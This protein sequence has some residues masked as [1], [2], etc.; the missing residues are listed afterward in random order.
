[1]SDVFISY[2][3][4][5]RVFARRLFD[6][7]NTQ[8]KETWVDWEDIPYSTEWWQEICSGIEGADTFIIIVTPSALGSKICNDELTY[9]YQLNKRIVPIIRREIK[10]RELAGTWFEK[11]WEFQARENW[12]ILKKINWLFFRRKDNCE[13][14]YNDKNELLNP[15]CDGKDCDHDNFD[16]AFTALL[17]SLATDLEHVRTHTR[18]LV[19]A[20]EWDKKKR[21]A[22]FLLRGA[23]LRDAENWLAEA[24]GKEQ[25]PDELHTEYILASRTAERKR[26]Q[27]N[28][29]ALAVGLLVAISLAIFGLIQSMN[30]N[31]N[32]MLAVAAEGTAIR[33]RDE[34]VAR[35][36]ALAASGASEAGDTPLG[37]A[38]ALEAYRLNPEDPLVHEA[39]FDQTQYPE[40]LYSLE[41][42]NMIT[43]TFF[44]PDGSVMY[45][46]E[47][48]GLIRAW[49]TASG[50][51]VNT[52][53]WRNTNAITYAQQFSLSPDASRLL[54]GYT[55]GTA[56]IHDTQNG[57]ILQKLV[58][59]EG[60]IWDVQWSPDSS[61]VLTSTTGNET[62]LP[63]AIVW[64]VA[65]GER[66]SVFEGHSDSLVAARFMPDGSR[67]IS[68]GGEFDKPNSQIFEWDAATGQRL[69]QID[70]D[71]QVHT[72][73]VLSMDLSSDG[74]LLAVASRDDAKLVIWNMANNNAVPLCQFEGLT[75]DTRAIEVEFSPDDAYLL[76]G[77]LGGIVRL[78]NV[79]DCREEKT[80]TLSLP[81]PIYGLAFSPDGTS[82]LISAASDNP[83]DY[84]DRNS[85]IIQRWFWDTDTI[86]NYELPQYLKENIQGFGLG[87]GAAF[88]DDN[89]QV[90]IT[91]ASGVYAFDAVSGTL[92]ARRAGLLNGVTTAVF[93][94]DGDMLLEGAADGGLALWNTATGELLQTQAQLGEISDVA[95]NHDDTLALSASTDGSVII[96][97]VETFISI[98]RFDGHGGE[99]V[100]FAHFLPDGSAVLS[101][102]QHPSGA[103][104]SLILWDVSTGNEIQRQDFEDG[105]EVYFAGSFLGAGLHEVGLSPDGTRIAYISD[106]ADAIILLET[107]SFEEVM[108]YEISSTLDGL[109]FSPASDQI[110]LSSGNGQ[111]ELINILTGVQRRLIGHQSMIS[112][113]AFSPDGASLL[114]FSG[115]NV[116]DRSPLQ[117]LLWDLASEAN[118]VKTETGLAI[119]GLFSAQ[120][121]SPDGSRFYVY[122]FDEQGRIIEFDSITL[123]ETRR[124]LVLEEATTDWIDLVVSPDGRWLAGAQGTSIILWEL[125]T[126]ASYICE[127]RIMAPVGGSIPAYTFSPDSSRILSSSPSE[128]G[129]MI[130]WDPVSCDILQTYSDP[131]NDNSTIAGL[132]PEAVQKLREVWALVYSPDGQYIYSGGGRTTNSGLYTEATASNQ[133]IQWDASTGEIIQRFLVNNSGGTIDLAITADGTRLAQGQNL[134]GAT[135]WD[136]TTYQPI[137]QLGD[138]NGYVG[139]VA[140][141]PNGKQLL[142]GF[143]NGEII[144]WDIDTGIE[145]SKF[146]NFG[147]VFTVNFIP[148][149]SF[150]LFSTFDGEDSIG[151]YRWLTSPEAIAAWLRANRFIRDF[152]CIERDQYNI[153]PLCNAEGIV[154]TQAIIATSTP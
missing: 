56:L 70:P 125:T 71:A 48:P 34:A 142:T 106:A 91:V 72:S 54:I 36:L 146:T 79:V 7:L 127:T 112:T 126:G 131:D 37:N 26:Q 122:D 66:V 50:L 24:G 147:Q 57:A 89:Q 114:V 40:I 135:V 64:D 69:R 149:G 77:D 25:K 15:E 41:T 65:T 110:A 3:R 13:C 5:D 17:D 124:L 58:G 97:D 33:Q 109:V 1:M 85:P 130:A 28:T 78:W 152:T 76:S 100:G 111:L 134:T 128:D 45:G 31:R 21:D 67:V 42:P 141:S 137:R 74:N 39:L 22:S 143:D 62:I 103:L 102:S 136:T 87:E 4:K 47:V 68:V 117:G 116:E 6:A 113:M 38:L 95:F 98:Q 83:Q 86:V 101:S 132:S 61:R 52:G 60:V 2:S 73:R 19:R 16:Q 108:Q 107:S 14:D 138:P 80:H 75:F 20:S 119:T 46:I 59:P 139:A 115:A 144:L 118:R 90:L 96:W 44:S 145:V 18:L 121:F 154:P 81:Y 140:L 55:N 10:E 23:D 148:D 99:R 8:N 12:Q 88:T 9:A 30:A 94:S 129:G 120:P 82:V 151:V 63:I 93:S 150:A 53:V 35:S 123:K 29:L 27:T 92:L 84:L 49:D 133:L 104:S 32:L 11:D 105:N 153:E 43:D 51:P